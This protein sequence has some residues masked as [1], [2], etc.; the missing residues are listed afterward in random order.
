MTDTRAQGQ[1]LV[2]INTFTVKP[3]NIDEL[4]TL[5]IEATDNVMRHIPG[6]ISATFHISLDRK[7]LANYAQWRSKEDNDAMMANPAAREHMGK[8]AKLT[9]SFEPLYYYV[10][11]AEERAA[12]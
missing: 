12:P 10:A 7:H 1:P 6:F 11:H 4:L 8:A 2:L 5:L 3:E 9:E